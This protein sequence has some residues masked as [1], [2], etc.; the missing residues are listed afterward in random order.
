M[1][2]LLTAAAAANPSAYSPGPF[3]FALPDDAAVTALGVYGPTTEITVE[4][5]GG[6]HVLYLSFTPKELTVKSKWERL[7]TGLHQASGSLVNDP[8]F[9]EAEQYSVDYRTLQK[10]DQYSLC[11]SAVCA[12][13]YMDLLCT[14]PKAD[15]TAW[16]SLFDS[17]R[18][19]LAYDPANGQNRTV[20][21]WLKDASGD[22]YH[23]F[24]ICWGMSHPVMISLEEA[25]ERGI[26][27]CSTCH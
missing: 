11:L 20:Y 15:Y 13:G 2:L 7:I 10:N 16:K 23:S 3:R 4:F 18:S 9:L 14:V 25:V 8:L 6:A 5:H 24:P 17:I 19:T 21:V 1:C 26:E 27:P 22:K 12:T